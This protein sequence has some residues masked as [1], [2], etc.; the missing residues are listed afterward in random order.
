MRR[1]IS[2]SRCSE[3]RSAIPAALRELLR[4]RWERLLERDPNAALACVEEPALQRAAEHD[5]ALGRLALGV[6]AGAVFHNPERVAGIAP[7][8]GV[9]LAGSDAAA[10]AAARGSRDPAALLEQAYR[11]RAPWR[12]LIEQGDCPPPFERFLRLGRLLS[13][14]QRARLLVALERRTCAPDHASICAGAD[15]VARESSALWQWITDSVRDAHPP[16]AGPVQRSHAAPDQHAVERPL[17]AAA[18]ADAC[19]RLEAAVAGRRCL[20]SVAACALAA[21]AAAGAG[22]RYLVAVLQ[23][24]WTPLLLVL[25]PLHRRVGCAALRACR[26][27]RA[28]G[29]SSPS[30]RLRSTNSRAACCMAQEW[31]LRRLAKHAAADRALALIS[32]LAAAGERAARSDSPA[33]VVRAPASDARPSRIRGSLKQV[34]EL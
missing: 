21:F 5:P 4:L 23:A 12:A 3:R 1:A 9:P 11:Q 15:A 27:A 14:E 6:L 29:I 32:R 7:R 28:A 31:T 24:S 2:A 10:R 8:Y 13:L 22:T 20:L 25:W 18:A 16:P 30:I 33:R 17:Q 26:A 34:T 19:D